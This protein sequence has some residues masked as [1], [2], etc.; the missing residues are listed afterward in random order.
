[1]PRFPSIPERSRHVSDTSEAFARIEAHAREIYN[2]RLLTWLQGRRVSKGGDLADLE[3]EARFAF[4]NAHSFET[5]RAVERQRSEALARGEVVSHASAPIRDGDAERA[6]A[7]SGSL[8]WS[9][10]S[11]VVEAARAAMCD[12]IAGVLSGETSFSEARQAWLSAGA[13][14]G[15]T[16]TRGHADGQ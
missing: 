8:Q 13:K 12:A 7:P 1:M 2:L 3:L 15:W 14:Y 11:H 16:A 5:V 10:R 6:D 4:S 9:P